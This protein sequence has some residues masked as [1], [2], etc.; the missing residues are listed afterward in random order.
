MLRKLVIEVI[1]YHFNAL[2][3]AN[4][5]ELNMEL[6]INIHKNKLKRKK[7]AIYNFIK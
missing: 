4:F 6:N 1:F 3:F 7:T 2:K 5:G